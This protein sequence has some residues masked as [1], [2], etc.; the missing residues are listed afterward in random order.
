MDGAG[1]QKNM[2]P[3]LF[4]GLE[5]PPGS[6]NV[7]VIAAR[8]PADG[9]AAHLLGNL[10]HGLEVARRSNRKAGLND[11]DAQLEQRVGDFQFF[12]N[13]HAGARRL[14]A[15]AQRR[16]E[17]SNGSCS[18]HLLN[19]SIKSQGEKSKQHGGGSMP[20]R[21]RP[22]QHQPRPGGSKPE[23]SPG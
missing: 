5:R 19:P 9:R 23:V 3:R 17:D 10:P 13:V 7:L 8:E 16:I 14:L 6:V 15:V 4:G 2:D 11:V 1:S 12:G 22:G 21:G 18:G 20:T